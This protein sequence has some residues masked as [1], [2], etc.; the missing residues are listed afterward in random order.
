MAR[1]E[2]FAYDNAIVRNFAIA[3]IIFGVIGMLVGLL[4]ALQLVLPSLN[5]SF[6]P[7]TFGRIRPLHTNAAWHGSIKPLVCHLPCCV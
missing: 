2:K 3:T 5:F 1:V 4:A 7:T 6:A